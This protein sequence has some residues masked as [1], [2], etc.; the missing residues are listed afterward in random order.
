MC[1]NV[2][3]LESDLSFKTNLVV[4][5][6][7]VGF[8][9]DPDKRRNL[10]LRSIFYEHVQ[11]F[12]IEIEWYGMSP[13]VADCCVVFEDSID[14]S[15]P[16]RHLLSLFS[17]VGFLGFDWAE[18]FFVKLYERHIFDKLVPN[19]KS[20]FHLEDVSFSKFLLCRANL[21][22]RELFVCSNF[23]FAHAFFSLVK[24]P[25]GTNSKELI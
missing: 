15:P 1:W 17:E 11:F 18:R 22:L 24:E 4:V 14:R 25:V 8:E 12:S 21:A 7:G 9:H 16:E 13:A 20:S 3:L 23:C 19:V 5:V 6:N 10:V 2:C